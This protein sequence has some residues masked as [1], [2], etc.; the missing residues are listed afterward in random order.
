VPCSRAEARGADEE[1]LWLPGL[2]NPVHLDDDHAFAA[3]VGQVDE[4]QRASLDGA[5]PRRL[6]CELPPV[7][8]IIDSRTASSSLPDGSLP[9]RQVAARRVGHR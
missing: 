5:Q 6:A 1:L 3:D 4:H 2:A 9:G 8:K 7:E